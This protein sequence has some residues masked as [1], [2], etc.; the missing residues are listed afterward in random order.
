MKPVDP[1]ELP[2]IWPEREREWARALGR[3]RLGVEP[4]PDQ[5][6]KYR[7]ANWALTGVSAGIGAMLFALFAAFRSPGT[8]LIVGG[9]LAG[10]IIASAWIGYAR[11]GANAA[12]YLRERAE[13]ERLRV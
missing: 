9:L 13:V 6:E 5:L 10:P 2:S 11:M 4:I 1:G 8:G 7:R 3:L 12:R